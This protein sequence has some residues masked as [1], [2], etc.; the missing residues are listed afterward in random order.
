MKKQEQGKG[1]ENVRFGDP[2]IQAQGS[3]SPAAVPLWR[4]A[5]GAE[6]R[7]VRWGNAGGRRGGG[8]GHLDSTLGGERVG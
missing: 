6:S 3:L 2:N 4:P 1:V 7:A 5:L 8:E